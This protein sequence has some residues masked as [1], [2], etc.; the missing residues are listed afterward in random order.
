MAAEKVSVL[1][2]LPRRPTTETQLSEISTHSRQTTKQPTEAEISESLPL[3]LPYRQVSMDDN[4][5]DDP[6]ELEAKVRQAAAN[7]SYALRDSDGCIF[8]V[9][10]VDD[11]GIYYHGDEGDTYRASWEQVHEWFVAIPTEEL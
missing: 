8:W 5:T 9:D 3:I 1:N 2:F 11:G 7:D 10:T 4:N 6:A